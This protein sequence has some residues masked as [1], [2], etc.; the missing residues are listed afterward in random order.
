[1]VTIILR[2]CSIFVMILLGVLARKTRLL[3]SDT[4]N[5][6]AKL[7]MNLV[8]PAL[9]LASIT[10]NFT[11]DALIRRWT[12]PVGAFGI[13]VT[14]FVVGRILLPLFARTPAPRR[15]NFLFQCTINNYSFFPMPLALFLWGDIGVANLILS[16]LG[17]EIAVW[18]FGVYALNGQGLSWRSL[19]HLLTVPMFAIAAAL[20]I[21]GVRDGVLVS[22]GAGAVLTGFAPF[23]EAIRSG[24]QLFGQ[25]TIPLAMLIVGSR[26]AELSFGHLW[27]KMQA[28]IVL[29][30]LM[31]IPALAVLIISRLPLAPDVQNTL[32]LVAV[33][34]A[35]A[36][37]V[38]LSELYDGDVREAAA[39]VL[40]THLGSI[41]TVP[42]WLAFFLNR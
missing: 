34:P 8:Y 3:D 2:L 4:T 24:L 27:S 33:M 39:T 22:L 35:A 32:L 38:L 29:L 13:M 12:L 9:I 41:A 25:A 42:F 28:V 36:A 17:A 11:A 19:R 18:T 1:M 14:G 5:R 16:T 7:L 6:L 10:E 20:L 40:L 15:R 31:V 23:A 30:R 21:I 26:M 37:S